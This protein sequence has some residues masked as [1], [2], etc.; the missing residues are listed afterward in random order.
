MTGPVLSAPNHNLSK[1]ADSFD[2][3]VLKHTDTLSTNALGEPSTHTSQTRTSQNGILQRT[4]PS[5]RRLPC[6]ILLEREQREL[7][8]RVRIVERNPIFKCE[9]QSEIPFSEVPL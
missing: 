3:R 8:C 5:R 7:T 2:T 1:G 9:L 6:G 4:V